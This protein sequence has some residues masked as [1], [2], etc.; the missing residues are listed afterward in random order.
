M[1]GRGGRSASTRATL[2]GSAS[3]PVTSPCARTR[4]ARPTWV[5]RSSTRTPLAASA[6]CLSVGSSPSTLTTSPRRRS[7]AWLRQCGSWAMSP[8]FTPR[9]AAPRASRVAAWCSRWPRRSRRLPTPRSLTPSW[10]HWR[11]RAWSGTPRATRRNAP[12]TGR[13]LPTPPPTGLSSRR[14]SLCGEDASRSL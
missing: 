6:T 14:G 4:T 2:S 11:C 3:S 1:T 13:Q 7:P 8:S 5:A 9:T 12:C 10:R